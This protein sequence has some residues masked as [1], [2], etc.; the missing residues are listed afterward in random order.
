MGSRV[1]TSCGVFSCATG[2]GPLQEAE[3]SVGRLLE[4]QS[5]GRAVLAGGSG[6]LPEFLRPGETGAVIPWETVSQV[7]TGMTRLLLTPE[8]LRQMGSRGRSWVVDHFDWSVLSRQ[9]A[10]LFGLTLRSCLDSS[11]SGD[12][13]A[14]LQPQ[15]VTGFLQSQNGISL[16][17]DRSGYRRL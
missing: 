16:L 7:A 1:K 13:S 10:D 8:E 3:D 6:S 17:P 11:V 9:A 2:D 15:S 4:A 12:Q 5:C 14:E